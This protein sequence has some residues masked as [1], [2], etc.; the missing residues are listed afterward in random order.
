MTFIH[1]SAPERDIGQD[2]MVRKL[3]RGRGV[4]L[5]ETMVVVTIIGILAS[6]GV[7]RFEQAIEQSKANIAAANLR[8]IWTG[9]R[10]YWLQN[11]KFSPDLAT[12]RAANLLDPGIEDDNGGSTTSDGTAYVY[13]ISQSGGSAFQATA[14]RVNNS[15]SQGTLTIDQNGDGSGTVQMDLSGGVT[16]TPSFF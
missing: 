3:R 9:Q 16:I 8:A 7:P 13:T 14:R 10:A 1:C 2:R 15:G 4:T 11:N 6:M 12:L 5:I